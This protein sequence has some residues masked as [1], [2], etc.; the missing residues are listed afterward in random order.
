[1]IAVDNQDESKTTLVFGEKMRRVTNKSVR[2]AFL[3]VHQ[4]NPEEAEQE[5]AELSIGINERRS[6]MSILEEDLRRKT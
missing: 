6:R 1:M 4:P 3:E 2:H 5:A